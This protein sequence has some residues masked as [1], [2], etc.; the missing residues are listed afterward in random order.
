MLDWLDDLPY[1]TKSLLVFMVIL[2]I[3][4]F[5]LFDSSIVNQ[6]TLVPILVIKKF[7]VWRL[8]TAQ[9]FHNDI[10][11]LIMNMM[12]FYSLGN[13]FERSVGTLAFIYYM[14]IFGIISNLLD[15]FIAWFMLWGG[16][17]EHFIGGTLGFSGVLFSLMV[18]DTEVSPG[19]QRSVMGLFL[20]PKDLYP[21]AMLLFMS[22]IIPNAS[23]LGHGTGIV[24][25]YL[26]TIGLLKFIVPSS[27]TFAKI[28]RK[29]CCCTGSRG[30]K[31]ADNN[32]PQDRDYQP[33][34][35]FNNFGGGADN[36][37]NELPE[38]G[39]NPH[40]LNANAPRNNNNNNNN[41]HNPFQGTAHTLDA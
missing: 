19:S 28:E 25:G 34:A 24:V 31:P 6:I 35:F 18:I 15:A 16:R 27:Q 40:A 8:F 3:V 7:Q 30:Y 38:L 13:S 14:F 29:L 26:Y 1:G 9:F 2:H 41:H 36:D 4:K 22:I 32:N 37:N 33:Y 20:V 17:P 12:A 21:W 11:H 23:L 10:L 5:A 39:P